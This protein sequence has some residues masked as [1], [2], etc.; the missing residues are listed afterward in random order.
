MDKQNVVRTHN[1]TGYNVDE[2]WR[3]MFSET[4]Q[5]KKDKYCM[6]SFPWGTESSQINKDR[7]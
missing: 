5:S 7:K 2:P 4:S 6:T 1:D 3:H